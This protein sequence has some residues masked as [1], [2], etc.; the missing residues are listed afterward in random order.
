MKKM[1][2]LEFEKTMTPLPMGSS[3]GELLNLNNSNQFDVSLIK[4]NFVILLLLAE[5]YTSCL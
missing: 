4:M 1:I 2:E 3:L 5:M